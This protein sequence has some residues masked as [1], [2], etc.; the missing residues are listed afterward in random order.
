MLEPMA[1]PSWMPPFCRVGSVWPPPLSGEELSALCRTRPPRPDLR[2]ERKCSFV[3]R[4]RVR[5]GSR[6]RS[7][8]IP[9]EGIEMEIGCFVSSYPDPVSEALTNV[10]PAKRTMP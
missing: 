6:S 5:R 3:R 9:Y 4:A 10:V 7:S 2:A 1:A 8:V